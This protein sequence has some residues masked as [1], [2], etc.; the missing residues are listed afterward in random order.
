MNKSQRM[1][2]KA[3]ICLLGF[4]LIIILLLGKLVAG[5]LH[6]EEQPEEESPSVEVH[7]PVVETIHNIWIMEEDEAGIIVFHDGERK[8]CLLYPSP[9]PRDRGCG[10]MTSS[11]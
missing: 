6:K 5:F 9:S 8:S 11:A 10:R 2:L 1:Q 7:I 3:F 4:L